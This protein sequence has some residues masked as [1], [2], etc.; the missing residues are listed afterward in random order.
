M[1]EPLTAEAR[2][3]ALRRDRRRAR[4]WRLEREVAGP[5][6]AEL[7]GVVPVVYTL[8]GPLRV[9]VL[10]ADR[11][12]VLEALRPAAVFALDAAMR[13]RLGAGCIAGG[14]I[15][16]YLPTDGVVDRLVAEGLVGADPF[17]DRVLVRPWPGPP[18]LFA[19]I[20]P[21]PPREVLTGGRRAVERVR[22]LR[23]TVGAVVPRT[24][25]LAPLLRS[26]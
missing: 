15:H 26:S 1:V 18:R 19:V 13:L 9:H 20:G 16:C 11:D 10:E 7:R 8:L 21:P 4:A 24:D 2:L 6:W 17:P 12:R 5:L 14:D 25:L 22:L 3:S 23:E